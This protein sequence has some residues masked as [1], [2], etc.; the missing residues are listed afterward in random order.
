MARTRSMRAPV[1]E[2][3]R[4]RVLEGPFAGKVGVVQELD[5]QGGA[6]VMLGLLAVRLEVKDLVA[7]GRGRPL[8]SSSHRK[9]AP[10]VRS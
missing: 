8:L 10:P 6:R 9:P 7:E 4:V 5:G 3:A 2:G 1:V